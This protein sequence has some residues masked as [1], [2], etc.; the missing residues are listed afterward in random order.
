[1]PFVE[2]EQTVF[3]MCAESGARRLRLFDIALELGESLERLL[4]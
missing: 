4:F 1:M 3:V 2:D